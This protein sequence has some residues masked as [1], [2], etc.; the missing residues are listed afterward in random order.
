QYLLSSAPVFGLV[1]APS[2]LSLPSL[3]PLF[4][5]LTPSS[6]STLSSCVGRLPLPFPLVS[7]KH[8]LPPCPSLLCIPSSSVSPHQVPQLSLH[9]LGGYPCLS[10]LP[11]PWR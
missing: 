8:P 5:C 6:S 10:L 4:L 7:C 3:H 9:A 2:T 11:S 1:P